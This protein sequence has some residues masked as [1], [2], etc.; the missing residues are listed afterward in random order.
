V[1]PGRSIRQAP[2][3][4]VV[5]QIASSSLDGLNEKSSSVPEY[6][7]PKVLKN[8]RSIPRLECTPADV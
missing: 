2:E 4:F 1:G 7:K 5:E 6:Y 3:Y 8:I